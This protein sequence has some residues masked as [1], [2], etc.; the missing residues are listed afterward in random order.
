MYIMAD[1]VC[2][3][4]KCGVLVVWSGF[5]KQYIHPLD[6]KNRALFMKNKMLCLWFSQRL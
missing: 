5:R 6:E 1:S 4:N 2:D 3:Q